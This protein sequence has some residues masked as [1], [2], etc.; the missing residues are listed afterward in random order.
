MHEDRPSP[1]EYL[2]VSGVVQLQHFRNGELIDEIITKNLVTSAG[3]AA[4]AANVVSDVTGTKFDAIAIGTGTTAP[5]AGDTQLGAEI[6][7]GG[8]Q[9]ISAASVT[10][11]RVTTSTA[12]DTG[13]FVGTFSFSASYAVTEAG[14]LNN[15]TGGDMLSR[16][17]FAAINVIS[18]DSLQVTWKIQFS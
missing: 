8:G 15:S 9:R 17:T 4:V 1:N 16:Q 3:K 18:G 12:N 5:A 10:G 11:T 2:K 14:L 13:Q 7:G 6:T